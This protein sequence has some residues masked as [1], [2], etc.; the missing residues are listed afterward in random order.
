[1]AQGLLG[2]VALE[3]ILFLM[4]QLLV[5]LQDA[6]LPMA[7]AV[8]GQITLMVSLVVRVVAPAQ[9]LQVL[10]SVVL[11]YLVKVMWAGVMLE[12][13]L[14]LM[15]LLVGVARV[16]LEA[17]LLFLQIFLVMAEQAL[18]LQFQVL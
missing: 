8:A 16:L 6:L 7:A 2:L 4:L 14:S 13:L 9:V 1:L 12:I 11:A 15:R 17:L 5:H 10:K 3:I 18:H